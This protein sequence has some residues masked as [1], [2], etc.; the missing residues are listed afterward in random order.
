[1]ISLNY[2]GGTVDSS[3]CLK[4]FLFPFDPIA[5]FDESRS[6]DTTG[7]STKNF[8]NHT[9]LELTVLMSISTSICIIGTISNV[10]SLSY[11]LFNWSNKLGEK[12]LVLLNS[13]DLLVCFTGTFYLVFW[14]FVEVDL[15]TE[16]IFLMAYLMFVECTGFVTTLLTVVRSIASYFPF[17]EPNGRHLS[18]SF[19]VFFLFVT[20]KGVVL[21]YYPNV[22]DQDRHSELAMVYNIILLS[23]LLLAITVVLAANLL[24]IRKLIFSG[25]E[26]DFSAAQP[27]STQVN[28]HATITILILSALFC[29]FNILYSVVLC[30]AML[31]KDTIC[32]LFRNV[33]V[34]TAV[35]MNSAVNPFVYF[36]RKTEMRHFICRNACY[37]SSDDQR[38]ISPDIAISNCNSVA[39]SPTCNNNRL[40]CPTVQLNVG[41]VCLEK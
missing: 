16:T 26:M 35:P 21:L 24:T 20:L 36:C 12:L 25:N 34:S 27:P 15:V 37:C 8:K 1:M 40:G 19:A 9:E 2:R 33:V 7:K 29:F 3:I 6:D 11:F 13:M 4:M 10:M 31:G 38:N 14:K 17:Y 28:R 18:V 32:L 39:T 30:N 5:Y 41:Q 22:V 23:F